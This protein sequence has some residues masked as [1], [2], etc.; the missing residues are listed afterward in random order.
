MKPVCA[1]CPTPGNRGVSILR[2]NRG[3]HCEVVLIA[4]GFD[5]RRARVRR[6]VPI[7][8][9]TTPGR[10]SLPGE[11]PCG[12]T[13]SPSRSDR[14]RGRRRPGPT[15]KTAGRNGS[16]LCWIR[17]RTDFRASAGHGLTRRE[18]RIARMTLAISLPAHDQ[19]C[20]A[21]RC[22]AAFFARFPSSA[23]WC[24]GAAAARSMNWP[25]PAGVH[26]CRNA[27]AQRVTKTGTRRRR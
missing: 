17:R 23:P 20:S 3:E 27:T 7:T 1:I 13:M 8:R 26:R 5:G 15:A 14:R 18:E 21:I 10:T 12:I 4:V 25:A 2:R 11:P 9:S 19:N 6:R 24:R 16:R 22:Y